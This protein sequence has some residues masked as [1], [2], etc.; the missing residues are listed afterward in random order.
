MFEDLE[1]ITETNPVK[2][3]FTVMG[4]LVLHTLAVVIVILLPLIAYNK[5]PQSELLTFLIAPPPPPPAPAPAPPPPTNV[6]AAPKQA[7]I[8]PSKFSAPSEIP[9]EIPDAP[10]DD[11]PVVSAGN[12][13]SGIPGGVGAGVSGGV[14][15]NVI[16]GLIS[17]VSSQAAPP[18][19][20]KLIKREPMRIGG[21]IKESMRIRFV[22]PEYPELAKRARV[23]FTVILV[24]VIDEEGNVSDIKIQQGH[25]LLND[26]AV[27]AVKQ[28]KYTPTVLNGEPVP[29]TGTVNVVFSF[30]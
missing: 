21:N 5:L 10:M 16:G 14:S 7:V 3:F 2:R 22:K 25:P 12:I 4:S 1:K 11:A 18:P 24:I 6:Q 17:N 19:L 29:I 20:P 13:A 28:W 15:G 23:S 30:K 9:K 27:S 26:A 8:D